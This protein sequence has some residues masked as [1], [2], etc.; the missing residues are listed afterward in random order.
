KEIIKSKS[1]IV[2]A[3]HTKARYN[4]KSPR[5]ILMDRSKKLRKA[6]YSIDET[7]RDKFPT[8]NTTDVLENEID[9]CQKLIDVIEKE[10]SLTQYPKV[11]EPLNLLK[12]TVTDDIEHLQ[13]SE[14]KDAK[15]GHKTAASS[16]FGYKTHIAMC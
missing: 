1:I 14:D 5:E 8:K 7:M 3:T 10:D 13:I 6:I 16:F 9:Y 11:K 12:E 4:Q 2:D 15:V